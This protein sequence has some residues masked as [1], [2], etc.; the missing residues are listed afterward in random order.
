MGDRQSEHKN[1]NIKTHPPPNSATAEP[2]PWPVSPARPAHGW[3]TEAPGDF[4][5]ILYRT[6]SLS[7]SPPLFFSVRFFSEKKRTTASRTVRGW[8]QRNCEV[9]REQRGLVPSEH[10]LFRALPGPGRDAVP[11]LCQRLCLWTPPPWWCHAAPVRDAV[12][13]PCA[14]ANPSGACGPS[15]GFACAPGLSPLLTTAPRFD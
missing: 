13:S 15:L 4:G 6:G 2:R 10:R 7:G 3:W 11:A 12:L 1:P 9:I 8:G 5:R 14:P